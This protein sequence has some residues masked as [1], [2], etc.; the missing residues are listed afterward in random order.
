MI[1]RLGYFLLVSIAFVACKDKNTFG[2]HG[3]FEHATPQSKVY[4]FALDKANP[5]ALDSTVLSEKGEFVFNHAAPEVNF[6]K[7]S[8]GNNEYMII[9][10]NGDEI[11]LQAD[12]TDKNMLYSISGADEA[13]KLEILNVSKN[14]QMAKINQVQKKFDE[15]VAQQPEKRDAIMESLRPAY[16][17]EIENLNTEILKFAQDN[18]KSLAGFYAINLLNPAEYENE[19]IAYSDQIK[20]NFNN[21]PAVTEF[22]VKMSHLK[23]VQI[24]QPA[25]V[26]SINTIEGKQVSLSDFKGKYVLLDFWASWCQPCRQENPNVVKAYQAFKNKNFTVFGIS[27]DKDQAAWKQ[28]VLADHLTW[29][30]GGELMDFE[31]PAIKLYQVE[32]IPSSFLIDPQ[33]KIIAKN[34][35]GQQLEDFLSKT[36][37]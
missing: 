21:N 34:L 15:L 16:T 18:S 10:K 4:L 31:G 14:K 36:L 9:A 3:K 7:V 25:P 17:K 19:M 5:V 29:T 11:K 28:A 37:R 20:S 6:F 30:H 12:L 26:F 35:R 24:G 33:G 1:K 13:D 32:A 2:I 22:L 27:L 23:T 8:A